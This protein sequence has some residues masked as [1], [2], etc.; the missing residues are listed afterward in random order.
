VSA[1]WKSRTTLVVLALVLVALGF[2]RAEF[3]SSTG[4]H[5]SG[6]GADYEA[7]ASTMTL[8]GRA[9]F[10][11]RPAVPLLVG[12]LF[13]SNLTLGFVIVCAA[14]LFVALVSV[15]SL[16]PDRPAGL[17]LMLVLFFNYQVLFAAANP[18]RLDIVVLA[19]QVGFVGLALRGNARLYFVLLPL[20]ALLKESMLLSLAAL[21]L[22]AFPRRRSTM[23]QI[24]G[25]GGAF[26]AIH[27]AVRWLARPTAAM[28]PYSG[29]AA[30]PGAMLQMLTDNL[31]ASLPLHFFVAWSGLCFL[32]LYVACTGP[33]ASGAERRS[34]DSLLVGVSAFLLVFPLPLATDIHRAWFELFAP[35]VLFVVLA[36]S[37]EARRSKTL[38]ALGLALGASLIPYAVRL[39]ASEHLHLLILRAQLSILPLA[40]LGA[41][42]GLASMA[43]AYWTR[44][45]C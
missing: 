27:L 30:D 32:A 29:G 18:A 35:T 40:A 1:R 6:D 3:F 9:P 15:G 42:L 23:L 13:S 22:V 11:Y 2:A 25:A 26:V 4:I 44:R 34:F 38:P 31:S 12:A 5:I 7:V 33:T 8:R 37:T 41:S 20:C 45:R 17:A 36:A 39:V 24:A 14:S 16:A 43:L 21:A 28:P 19:V 10:V